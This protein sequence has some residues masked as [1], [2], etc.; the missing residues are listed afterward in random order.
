MRLASTIAL[1]LAILATTP[2]H[3]DVR[4]A[5]RSPVVVRYRTL[6]KM[7]RRFSRQ[8]GTPANGRAFASR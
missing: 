5:G 6:E 3:A 2:A 8:A 4:A 7:L 1:A